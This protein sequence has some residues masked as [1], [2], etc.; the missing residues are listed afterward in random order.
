M[1]GNIFW[2]K[3]RCTAVS[4]DFMC[5]VSCLKTGPSFGY[6]LIEFFII[7]HKLCHLDNERKCGFYL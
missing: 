1:Y 6:F 4:F 3:V 5:L 2:P 7:I